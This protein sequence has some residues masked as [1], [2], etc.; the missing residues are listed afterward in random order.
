M[1]KIS[2]IL[3]LIC[4]LSS[5]F[6]VAKVNAEEGSAYDI[7]FLKNDDYIY[8]IEE[9]SDD[10]QSIRLIKYI[11]EN[12]NII[13][14]DTIDDINIVKIDE[15]FCENQD[16]VSVKIGKYV[17]HI[18]DCAFDNCKNLKEVKLPKNLKYIGGYAFYD[19]KSLK[20]I[21]IPNTVVYCGKNSFA[22]SFKGTIK[23]A[24]YLVKKRV[25][26]TDDAYKYMAIAKVTY[27]KNKKKTTK[28]Y[29]VPR[30]KKISSN[31]KKVIMCKDELYNIT[32]KIYTK[33]GKRKGNLNTN[34]L[35]FKSLDKS[36]VKVNKKGKIK[37]ISE[38]NAKVR[39]FMKTDPEIFYDIKVVIKK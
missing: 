31:K 8:E 28:S 34:I 16:I 27:K 30:V 20:E 24:S 32:T 4:L 18:S 6:H 9:K 19:C 14:P 1:K 38:G 25:Y 37:A 21:K 17:T 13:I 33:N 2:Y 39:V 26:G 12:K 35:K 22:G 11:G 23:K 5:I 3:F 29:W 15:Q 36:V 7:D 10:T